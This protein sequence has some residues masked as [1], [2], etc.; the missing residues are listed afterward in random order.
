MNIAGLAEEA[1]MI[2]G[3]AVASLKVA[4]LMRLFDSNEYRAIAGCSIFRRSFFSN[5]AIAFYNKKGFNNV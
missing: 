5:N 1:G 2:P 3:G 4:V